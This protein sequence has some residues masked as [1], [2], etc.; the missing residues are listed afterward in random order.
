MVELQ[1]Q[2]GSHEVVRPHDSMR[3]G[4]LVSMADQRAF[5]VR[6][7]SPWQ[8]FY[9]VLRRCW[10]VVSRWFRAGYTSCQ[11]VLYLSRWTVVAFNLFPCQ[12]KACRLARGEITTHH[13]MLSPQVKLP[14]PAFSRTF[15]TL[16]LERLYANADCVL[17][18]DTSMASEL[19]H[20]TPCSR[21]THRAS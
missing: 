20:F 17:Q 7:D 5:A 6:Q 10:F 13:T 18:G 9:R 12:C 16:H 21:F 4:D 15:T 2:G 11:P 1:D 14:D 19:L 8:H 3:M